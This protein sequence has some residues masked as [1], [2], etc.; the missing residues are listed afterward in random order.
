MSDK[1]TCAFLID[2]GYSAG[3][4]VGLPLLSRKKVLFEDGNEYVQAIRNLFDGES[5]GM[6]VQSVPDEWFCHMYACELLERMREWVNSET[7]KAD[8]VLVFPFWPVTVAAA[9]GMVVHS[10]KEVQALFPEA[11]RIFYVRRSKKIVATEA[12]RVLGS[13]RIDPVLYLDA[14][15]EMAAHK[16]WKILDPM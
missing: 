16:G 14:M 15:E 5:L 2:A 7:K 9:A 12:R 3:L 1:P 4:E 11:S 6:D 10:M 13:N 8:D